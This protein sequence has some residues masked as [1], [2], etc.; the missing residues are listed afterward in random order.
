M[1]YNSYE[2]WCACADESGSRGSDLRGRAIA[3]TSKEGY[4]LAQF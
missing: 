2:P 1:G 4:V 3:L